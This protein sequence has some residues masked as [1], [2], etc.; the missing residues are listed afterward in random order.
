[1][2]Y[3]F[4]VTN[5]G[6]TTLTDAAIEDALLGGALDCATLAAATLAPGDAV[7]CGPIVYTLTQADIDA[8]TV[9]NTASVTASSPS[10]SVTDDADAN[11]TIAATNGVNLTKTAGEPVD[12]DRDGALGAG[13]TIDYAFTVTNTGTTTLTEVVV[14]DPMLGGV[15]ECPAADGA[16]LAPGDSL[17]CATVTYTLTQDDIDGGVVSNSAT[18]DAQAPAAAVTDTAQADTTVDGSAS[19]ELTKT[20]GAI[21]DTTG[22][23]LIGAGDEVSYTFTVTNTGTVTLSGATIV[24]DRLGGALECAP[25]DG[26]AL[27]PG[28]AIDCGPY[29]YTITQA[30]VEAENVHNEATVTA[31][32]AS[33]AISDDASADV[34]IA[35]TDAVSLDKVGSAPIDADGDGRIGAGDGIEYTFTV[36]NTGTTV[37][38]ELAITDPLLGGE[39]DCPALEGAQPA[40]VTS[41]SAAP[42]P[43]RSRRR[44]STRRPSATRPRRPRRAL[45]V[46][47]RMSRS[48]TSRSP[49]E[50]AIALVKSAA[51]IVDANGNGVTDAGDTIDY[52]FAVTNTGTTTVSD[53]TI[54]DA[55]VDGAIVC[56][57]YSIAPDDMVVCGPVTV[58][59]TQADVDAGERSSTPPRS[60]R[61]APGASRRPPRRA[62]PHRS[63]RSPRSR[64][65]RPAVTSW[66]RT[67]TR[68]SAPATPCSSGSP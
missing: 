38:S 4:T 59:L 25:L 17:A 27:A 8:A 62:S 55:R 65:R 21:A 52:T 28:D 30:D 58:A 13:D 39:L 61:R 46:L 40:P 10:A 19:I 43:T 7:D 18:V 32:G 20:P 6:T 41:S 16:A 22:D 64:W 14:T 9:E 35:G 56:E 49:R 3:S 44:T 29:P 60:P 67:A 63:R 34:V 26:A 33:G 1:M 45:R 37:L 57:A 15:V 42:S 23:G 53:P 47:S 12:V 5:T 2:S 31:D 50:D 54:V 68:R 11:V 24:D 51:A 36:R 48:R 66:M